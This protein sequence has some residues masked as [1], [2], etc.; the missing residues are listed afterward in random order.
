MN[1]RR[2]SYFVGLN[3]ASNGHAPVVAG[4]DPGKAC[5]GVRRQK[6][7]PASGSVF[8]ELRSHARAGLVHDD[9]VATGIAATVAEV[10]GS[11]IWIAGDQFGAEDVAG[12]R[13]S[14][15]DSVCEVRSLR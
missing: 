5:F 1:R 6:I 3:P 11:G 9:I 14:R 15:M 4:F 2:E 7:N 13:S 10:T 12:H 8:Q